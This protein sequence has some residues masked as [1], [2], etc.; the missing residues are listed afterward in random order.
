[1]RLRCTQRSPRLP[2]MIS[3]VS[4][5]ASSD[6][7]KAAIK[8]MSSGMPV[9]PSGV[10]ALIA[11]ATCLYVS[12][13]L[14][15]SVSMTPCIDRVHADVSCSKLFGH[16]AGNAI[17]STFGCGVNG[18]SKRSSVLATEPILIMLPPFAKFLCRTFGGE[19]ET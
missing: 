18:R 15:P 19:E 14:T 3:P 11:V 4:Q 7:R 13:A 8:P 6:A 16:D 9:R 5:R 17:H 12:I 1:M 10:M 2:K